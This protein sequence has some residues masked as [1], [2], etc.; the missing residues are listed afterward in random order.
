MRIALPAMLLAVV[1]GGCGSS[2]KSGPRGALHGVVIAVGGGPAAGADVALVSTAANAS[3]EAVVAD[4]QGRYGFSAL[5]AGTY[6]VSALSSSGALATVADTVSIPDGEAPPDTLRLATGGT[7]AGTVTAGAGGPPI[8]GVSLTVPGLLAPSATSDASG[9]WTMRG[10]LP[11][12]RW[13]VAASHV[14]YA[15]GGATAT[16]SVP[17]DSVFVPI[18]L[19]PAASARAR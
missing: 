4:G 17:G 5:V 16:I 13:T 11:T 2:S 8:A 9:Q 7:F 3:F 15:D 19:A 18:V 10:V 1:L 6:I 12:G 14:G